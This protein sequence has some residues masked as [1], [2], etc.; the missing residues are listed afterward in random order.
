MA[1]EK[2]SLVIITLDN[3]D[4]LERCLAAA[5]FADG[6]KILFMLKLRNSSLT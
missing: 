1:R 2:F 4:T 3:A 6:A 5:D